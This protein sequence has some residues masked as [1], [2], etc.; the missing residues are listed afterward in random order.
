MTVKERTLLFNVC[1]GVFNIALG[2]LICGALVVLCVLALRAVGK[3]VAGFAPTN[4]ILPFILL[5]GLFA[6]IAVSR[7]LVIFVLDRFGLRDRLDPKMT[8]R[9]PS[10]E[11]NSGE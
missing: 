7:R 2:L 9:Y 6:S 4:A 5:V 1:V 11:K 10:K 3:E 8:S